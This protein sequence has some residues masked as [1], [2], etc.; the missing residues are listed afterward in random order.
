MPKLT[1]LCRSILI[2]LHGRRVLNRNETRLMLHVLPDSNSTPLPNP[3]TA[4]ANASIEFYAP[5][6][7][8]YDAATSGAAC[9]LPSRI[10]MSPFQDRKDLLVAFESADD[11]RQDARRTLTSSAPLMVQGAT[12]LTETSTKS[13][14]NV[15]FADRFAG[16]DAL[17]QTTPQFLLCRRW[18]NR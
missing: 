11:H 15:Q 18:R 6:G 9:Q 10:R 7:T 17:R 4:A 8:P 14:N 3:F 12:L 2:V 1:I 5:Q 16:K 13:L